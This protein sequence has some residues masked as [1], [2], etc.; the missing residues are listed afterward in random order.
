MFKNKEYVLT[1]YKE[2]G[3]TKASEKL[4]VSQPSLSASIKRIE[5]KVGAPI[6]DRSV[7]PVALTEIGLE[8]VRFASQ[9]EQI[10]NDFSKYVT[11]HENLLRGK[12]KIG[13]SSFFS[14]FILPKLIADFNLKHTNIDFEIIEDSSKNLLNKLITGS[15]D[16]VIDNAII[17]DEN[18]LS[19]MHTKE[20]LLLAVPNRFNINEK[21]SSIRLSAQDV[22]DNK[23]LNQEY[24]ANLSDFKNEPFILLRHEND[25]GKRAENLF[26]KYNITPNVIFFLEQQVTAYN[27]SC[28]GM[29]ISFVSDTLVKNTGESSDVYY[30]KL[31][32]NLATRKVYF[33]RKKN[34]YLSLACRKFL[35]YNSITENI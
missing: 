22:K 2:G 32:D 16:I 27:V 30:Y 3:F 21:L 17:T 20:R 12:I 15:V 34:H 14:S 23:H 19:E 26:K 18:I 10:E 4:F 7:T 13:G 28:S 31:P 9:I 33:Y 5:D 29:G 35:E 1:V 8:Y 11:D 24:T 25:T 6:F